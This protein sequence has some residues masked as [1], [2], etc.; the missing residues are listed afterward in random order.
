MTLWRSMHFISKCNNLYFTLI[1]CLF[2]LLFKLIIND[3]I[4]YL[5]TIVLELK[6]YLKMISYWLPCIS[7]FTVGLCLLYLS[8]K[9]LLKIYFLSGC[10]MSKKSFITLKI[11]PQMREQVNF[12]ED[13]QSL[14][15]MIP[16]LQNNI[17]RHFFLI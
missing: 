13:Y 5:Q 2:P 15:M 16:F 8:T 6:V 9:Y 17:P 14:I 11:K 3:W 4:S 10:L 12:K 7:S 1:L